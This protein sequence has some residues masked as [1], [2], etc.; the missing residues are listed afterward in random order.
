MWWDVALMGV[1]LLATP[2]LPKVAPTQEE[3]FAVQAASES[4]AVAA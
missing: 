1:V 2:L 3:V 4:V